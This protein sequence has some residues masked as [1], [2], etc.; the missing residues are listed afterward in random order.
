MAASLTAIWAHWKDSDMSGYASGQVVAE[1]FTIRALR[2]DLE[3][4]EWIKVTGG[5]RQCRPAWP[6]TNTPRY[7]AM[8]VTEMG[9]GQISRQGVLTAKIKRV[10]LENIWKFIQGSLVWDVGNI[11]VWR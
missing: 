4:P 7:N 9:L 5:K 6:N 10:I 2:R 3:G 11:K 1:A 8:R